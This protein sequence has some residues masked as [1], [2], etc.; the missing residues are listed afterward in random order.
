MEI[1]TNSK[2]RKD[3]QKLYLSKRRSCLQN[4]SLDVFFSVIFSLTSVIMAKEASALIMALVVI[5]LIVEI[6]KH[7]GWVGASSEESC[8][9]FFSCCPPCSQ[10]ETFF[11]LLLYS[12]Y[13][14]V[15]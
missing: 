12:T 6:G 10:L 11:G 1:S 15:G 14:Q 13:T 8:R 4:W 5:G 9:L 3:L 7:L 2:L